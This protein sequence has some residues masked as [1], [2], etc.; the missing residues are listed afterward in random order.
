MNKSIYT[1]AALTALSLLCAACSNQPTTSD[2]PQPVLKDGEIPLP[3]DYKTWP[4]FLEGVQRPDNKQ[5]R[6]IY[7]NPKGYSTTTAK[8]FPYGTVMVMENY[9]AHLSAEGIPTTV[10]GK[11]TKDTLGAIFVMGKGKGWGADMSDSLST[12]EWI[13]AAY[14]PD[15]SKSD[16]DLKTC[17]SCHAPLKTK[18]FVHRYDEYFTKRSS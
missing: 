16:A 10:D 14:K 2:Q 9:K 17:R 12:G 1:V 15:G 13:F 7:I 18:D 6:D 4:K 5:V 3:A 11:M 8:P